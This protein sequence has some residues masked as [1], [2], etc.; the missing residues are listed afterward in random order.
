MV[1][2]SLVKDLNSLINPRKKINL[3]PERPLAGRILGGRGIGEKKV[4]LATGTQSSRPFT[5][6]VT[7]YSVIVVTEDG[8]FELPPN[9]PDSGA[10]PASAPMP[11][12]TPTSISDTGGFVTLD[13]GSLYYLQKRVHFVFYEQ[14]LGATVENTRQDVLL[15]PLEYPYTGGYY[16]G[17]DAV[18]TDW[19]PV[20]HGV[21][22]PSGTSATS[23]MVNDLTALGVIFD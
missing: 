22:I 5:E 16:T 21:A 9:W 17:I 6:A 13:P 20:L 3:L 7:V 12:P 8:A 11:V 18:G 14:R 19:Q 4:V 2:K 15:T 23:D 10:Y 1:N